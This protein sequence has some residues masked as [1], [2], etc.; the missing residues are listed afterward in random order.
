MK[1]RQLQTSTDPYIAAVDAFEGLVMT[2]LV[3]SLQVRVLSE[4]RAVQA[5]P[6]RV[7]VP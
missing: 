5:W 4:S 6:S 3:S 7:L 1:G 2:D